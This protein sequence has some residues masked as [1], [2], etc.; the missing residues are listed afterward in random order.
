MNKKLNHIISSIP[1]LS[2]QDDLVVFTATIVSIILALLAP[3]TFIF[4]SIV[5]FLIGIAGYLAYIFFH[6]AKLTASGTTSVVLIVVGILMIPLYGLAAALTG[7]IAVLIVLSAFPTIINIIFTYLI[8]KYSPLSGIGKIILFLPLSLML[9]IS[10]KIGEIANVYFNDK[11]QITTTSR[12][13]LEAGESI[14]VQGDESWVLRESPFDS[15]SFQGGGDTVR[16][17]NIKLFNLNLK[18]AVQSTMLPINTKQKSPKKIVFSSDSTGRNNFSV[19]ILNGNTETA[20][21]TYNQKLDYLLEKDNTELEKRIGFLVYGSI[22]GHLLRHYSNS[23]NEQAGL[24]RVKVIEFLKE[25]IKDRDGGIKTDVLT[26]I[27]IDEDNTSVKSGR[28]FYLE[29]CI[30]VDDNRYNIYEFKNGDRF[31]TDAKQNWYKHKNY[32]KRKDSTELIIINNETEINNNLIASAH[33]ICRPNEVIFFTGYR[34]NTIK[35]FHF[36]TTGRASLI[37]T[38]K[39]DDINP[40][41][42][43]N[44]EHVSMFEN[45]YIIKLSLRSRTRGDKYEDYKIC[46]DSIDAKKVT[47]TDQH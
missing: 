43:T 20:R 10:F 30:N 7:L 39:F 9:G 8:L 18:E 16:L 41:G 2:T 5:L 12:L 29:R 37:H 40:A 11:I 6:K 38:I 26:P 36:D 24:T 32:F 22:W 28:P 42:A 47:K 1:K 21:L 35:A 14:S 23:T 3:P 13:L 31:I 34:K 27:L 19:K 45:C 4:I 44:V 15:V 17:H 33:K 46:S 25:N